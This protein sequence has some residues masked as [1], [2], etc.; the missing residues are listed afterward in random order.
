MI[1][2]YIDGGTVG[3]RICLV[4]KLKNKTLVKIRG[5][6]PT[7]NELE[8][9]ALVYALQYITN[10]Y[11]RRNITIY[12]D[13]LLVVNQINGKWRI[14]TPTLL[15]IWNKCMKMVTDKIKIKWISRD[16]NEAGWVLD[17]LRG[18]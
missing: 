3:S 7:N 11:K 10:N 12:S 1:K 15:P 6:D 8:Y 17:A 18:K 4:D 9:L 5:V 16:F 14:T 13:S 2:L